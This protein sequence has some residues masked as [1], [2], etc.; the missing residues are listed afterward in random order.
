M[1]ELGKIHQIIFSIF[2]YEATFNLEVMVMTWIVILLLLLFGWACSSRRSMVPNRFQ[3]VGELLV[4]KLYEL[5][6]D[7]CHSSLLRAY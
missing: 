1:Q 2:G 6:E 7:A 5:T 4:S 3:V